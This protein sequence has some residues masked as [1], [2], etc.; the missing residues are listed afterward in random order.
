MH[1]Y[2]LEQPLKMLRIQAN[3][4][5]ISSK[6]KPKRIYLLPGWERSAQRLTS[7]VLK[8]SGFFCFFFKTVSISLKLFDSSED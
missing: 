4:T 3:M 6:L 7:V 5:Q 8:V 1:Y 2:L